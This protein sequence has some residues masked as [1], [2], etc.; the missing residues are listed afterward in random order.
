MNEAGEDARPSVMSHGYLTL[1]ALSFSIPLER[2]EGRGGGGVFWL[3][4]A[5]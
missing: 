4:T 2:G 3:I 5:T 1:L